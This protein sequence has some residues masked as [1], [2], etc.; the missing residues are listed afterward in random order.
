[1]RII[2]QVARKSTHR[3]VKSKGETYFRNESFE[4]DYINDC[5]KSIEFSWCHENSVGIGSCSEKGII[6]N[7]NDS[8]GNLALFKELEKLYKEILNERR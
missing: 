4:Y 1:M 3:T 5:W 8:E 6:T 2:K 7:T